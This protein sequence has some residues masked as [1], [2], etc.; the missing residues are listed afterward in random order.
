MPT[1]HCT[2]TTDR[3]AA[4]VWAAVLDCEAFPTYMAE[5]VDVRLS[6]VEGNHRTAHWTVLLK[7]SEL[8]W[9]EE[10]VI[11]E[12][13]RRIDF[14]QIDGDL[15]RFSGYWRVGEEDARTVVELHVDF[16]IGIPL[17]ADM[18]NPVA[19]RALEDNSRAI[20][21]GLSARARDN[22]TTGEA[23]A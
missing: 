1:V 19:A 10:E 8:E 4:D 11:D 13:A 15:E 21:A 7:G 12:E 16:D 2:H 17:M 20:L 14:S 3:P 9:E 23:P 18:L 5:V 6:R 22:A